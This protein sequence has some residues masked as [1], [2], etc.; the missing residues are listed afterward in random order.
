M[1]FESSCERGKDMGWQRW[2]G[3]LCGWVRG[4]RPLVLV[5]LDTSNQMLTPD[6][7]LRGVGDLGGSGKPYKDTSLERGFFPFYCAAF[8]PALGTEHIAK[9]P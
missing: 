2:Q 1:S 9:I 7:H 4:G 6:A 3:G 8:P 5:G